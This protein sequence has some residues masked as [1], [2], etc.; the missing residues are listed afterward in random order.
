MVGFKVKSLNVF[1]LLKEGY[2][3]N[4][5]APTNIIPLGLNDKIEGGTFKLSIAAF[6]Y[7]T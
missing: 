7:T 6:L 1:T 4:C 2:S 5:D 3:Y